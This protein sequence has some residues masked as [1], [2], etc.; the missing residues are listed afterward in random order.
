MMGVDLEGVTCLK[1]PVNALTVSAS[2]ASTIASFVN[3]P[4]CVNS[5]S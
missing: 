2:I 3:L 5:R 4:P 1:S